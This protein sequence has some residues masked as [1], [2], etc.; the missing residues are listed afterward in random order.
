[1]LW[2]AP[3]P[4]HRLQPTLLPGWGAVH[5]IRSGVG[6]SQKGIWKVAGQPEVI[7]I[8]DVPGADDLDHALQQFPMWKLGFSHILLDFQIIPLRP[9]ENWAE[10]LTKG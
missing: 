8:I 10:D 9:Y 6:G 4:V 2:T 7:T 3:H 5:S 1:M